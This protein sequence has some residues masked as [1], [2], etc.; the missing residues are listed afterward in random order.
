VIHEEIMQNKIFEDFGK[1]MNEDSRGIR[2]HNKG[3]NFVPKSQD[4]LHGSKHQKRL[5]KTFGR[6]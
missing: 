6:S 5:V 4:I 1:I 3:R 2:R